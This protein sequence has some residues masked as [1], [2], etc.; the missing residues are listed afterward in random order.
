[1]Q[2]HIK[3]LLQQVAHFESIPSIAIILAEAEK[4]NLVPLI[5]LV[6]NLKKQKQKNEKQVEEKKSID[7]A[8]TSSD[9]SISALDPQAARDLTAAKADPDNYTADGQAFKIKFRVR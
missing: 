1:M 8:R 3:I 5:E 9:N 2:F 4:G 7:P 6:N